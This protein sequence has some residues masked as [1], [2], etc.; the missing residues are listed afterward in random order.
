[1]GQYFIR[2][3]LKVG[4]V[5]WKYHINNMF[6]EKACSCFFAALAELVDPGGPWWTLVDP[7]GPYWILV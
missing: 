6:E 4:A 7:G 3:F 1:M 5:S 2:I